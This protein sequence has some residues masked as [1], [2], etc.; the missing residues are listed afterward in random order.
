VTSISNTPAPRTIWR[1]LSYGRVV[2]VRRQHNCIISRERA[3]T[4]REPP[5]CLI[6]NGLASAC[7]VNS[8]ASRP[9]L[10]APHPS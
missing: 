8:V 3:A 4:K 6:L 1:A 7:F 10:K 9:T 5:A 2:S